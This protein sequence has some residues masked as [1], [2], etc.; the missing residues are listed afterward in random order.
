MFSQALMSI[1]EIDAQYYQDHFSLTVYA[2]DSVILSR[3]KELRYTFTAPK[4][5]LQNKNT[6]CANEVLF[7]R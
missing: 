5:I 3:E 7:D 1:D 2:G 4:F 6:I